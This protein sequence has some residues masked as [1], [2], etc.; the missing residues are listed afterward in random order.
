[1]K[2]RRDY[3]ALMARLEQQARQAPGWYR[4]KLG[5]LGALGYAV[6]GGALLVT[7]GAGVAVLVRMLATWPD[8]AASAVIP[9]IILFGLGGMVLRAC[10]V[11]L[12]APE[13]YPLHPTE[14]PALW[15]EIDQLRMAAGA[16]P[17]HAVILDDRLNAAAAYLPARFG[18][19]GE[20]RYLV[21]GLPLLQALSPAQLRAVIAH[22]FG[23]FHGRHGELAGWIYGLRL[24]WQR[25]AEGYG[26]HGFLLGSLFALFFRWYAPYFNAYSHALARQHE[27]AADA[28]AAQLAGAGATAASLARLQRASQDLEDDFWPRLWAQADRQGYPPT[29]VPQRLARRLR[30]LATRVPGDDHWQQEA[31][32]D[33]DDTH[34]RLSQRLAAL[35]VRAAQLAWEP[36]APAA[37][38]WLPEALQQQL[39]QRFGQAWMEA[40]RT[41]WQAR[42][43]AAQGRRARLDALLAQPVHDD[44]EAIELGCLAADFLPAGK[45]ITLLGE[46]LPRNPRHARGHLRLGELLLE[47]AGDDA[48]RQRLAC[49]HLVQAMELDP[50]AVPAALARLRAHRPEA[51]VAGSW[52]AELDRLQQRHGPR[53]AALQAR[54]GADEEDELLPHG[55]DAGDWQRLQRTLAGHEKVAAA[56]VLQKRLPGLPAEPHFVLMLDWKGSV[57]SEARGLALLSAQLKLPG[58]H[59]VLTRTERTPLVQAIQRSA[60]APHY[61]RGQR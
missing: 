44:A 54:E 47:D 8:N 42:H 16:P 10:W 39:Q 58:S 33:P 59:T 19:W 26:E 38:A 50:L 32:A 31:A 1:M 36:D 57:A 2:T 30:E 51:A 29:D 6:M 25:L 46:A 9:L 56:W 28:V 55:L 3:R 27:Y 17:L 18:L 48:P 12:A 52:Q 40:A 53:H 45:A 43:A 7:L 35:G 49:D 11:R 13:G 34:P 61:R 37:V 15:Q 60:D 14:A 4:L 22:E 20:Q 21:L 24:R 23:H 41:P 5:L